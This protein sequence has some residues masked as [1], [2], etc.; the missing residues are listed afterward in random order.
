[1]IDNVFYA[2]ELA[3]LGLVSLMHMGSQPPSNREMVSR[4]RVI[5]GPRKGDVSAPCWLIS[6]GAC[7]GAKVL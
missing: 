3:A 2:S 4:S 5:V 6:S 1:M 7:S